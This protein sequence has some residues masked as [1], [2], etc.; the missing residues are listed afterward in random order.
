MKKH[1]ILALALCITLPLAAQRYEGITVLECNEFRED[2][3]SLRV[4]FELTLRR[5]ATARYAG[6]TLAPVVSAGDRSVELP[7]VLVQ[8]KNKARS[9]DRSIKKLGKKQRAAYVH[10]AIRLRVD[11]GADMVIRYAA[12]VP[13]EEWMDGARMLLRQE[14]IG[15]RDSRALVVLGLNDRVELSPRTPYEV[16]PKPSLVVPEAEIKQR[17]KQGSAF[18]DFQAG[19]SEIIPGFRRNPEELAKIR[20]AFAEVASNPDVR[21]V[22]LFIDGYASPEGPYTANEKLARERAA[23]LRDYILTNYDVPLAPEQTKVGWTAEDWNGLAELVR[24]S[25]LPRR[26]EILSMIESVPDPDQRE[27]RI[28]ALGGGVPYRTILREMYPSL[29]RVE[30]RID[31]TV[32]DYSVEEARALTGSDVHL[33]SHRELFLAARSYGC[34]SAEYET[35]MLDV[36]PRLFPDDQTAAVNAA[37]VM[38][39]NGEYVSAKR[40]LSKHPDSPHAWNNRGA[41]MLAEGDLEGAEALFEKASQAGVGEAVHNLGELR[42][43]REDNL[44]MERYADR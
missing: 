8:G 32:R 4:G 35:I 33:L 38:I 23:A 21:I 42:K 27:A 37:A 19:R 43:K 7:V 29:R 20:D 13:Y 14:I 22:G 28:R 2:G 5:N 34:G 1:L 6:M 24:E 39:S 9:Y 12:A 44:R 31:Y 18:L 10:P 15:Y 36:I 25:S 3:D 30:Y 17:R 40:L 11:R 26:D 16:S 41:I